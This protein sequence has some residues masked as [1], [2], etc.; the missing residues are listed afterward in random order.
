MTLVLLSGAEKELKVKERFH[1]NE[2]E[3]IKY[4]NLDELLPYLCEGDAALLSFEEGSQFSSASNF[5]SRGKKVKTLFQKIMG[6]SSA[7]YSRFLN[8]LHREKNHLGH[9]Y[10]RAILEGWQYSSASDIAY[11][12]SLKDAVRKDLVSFKSGLNLS[13][14]SPYLYECQL[15]TETEMKC[16]CD[17]NNKIWI[18]SLFDTLDTKGPLAYSLFTRCLQKECS[19]PTHNEL[20]AKIM[21]VA[22]S[23]SRK[24]PLEED[25]PKTSLIKR[26]P[27]RLKPD[28]PLAGKRYEELMVT[29]QTC[30]HN[31]E[32]LKL[33]TEAQKYLAE[34]ATPC[35][36]LRIVTL[37]EMAISWIFRQDKERALNLVSKAKKICKMLSGNNSIF[38]QGRCEYVLS[39]LFRYL[40]VYKKARKHAE[41]AKYIL[42]NVEPGEDSAFANYCDACVLVESSSD[43]EDSQRDAEL[44]FQV[45]IDAARSHTSGLDLVAPHS[46]IRLAEMYLGSTHY[47]AGIVSDMKNLQKAE[48]C[49]R[50]VDKESLAVR[51]QC[52][53]HL[54]ESDLYCNKAMFSESEKA[55]LSESEKSAQHALDMSKKYNF[56]NEITSAEN[57]LQALRLAS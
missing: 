27:C 26:T 29:F 3:I 1:A 7:P 51:S 54:I 53:F 44:F 45:A 16:I 6:R 43:F 22:G 30:H 56:T 21:D 52:H 25:A 9:A 28:R 19:H 10:I 39:R 32:W 2:R 4:L 36:E 50:T 20:Y 33:E 47:K 11:S 14:L 40:K 37:L 5:S 48:D 13:E 35:Y 34:E 49:L 41:R 55:M 38:L 42:F 57:R 18:I 46:F 15:L 17:P 24:R 23:L 31:G 12:E 8:C